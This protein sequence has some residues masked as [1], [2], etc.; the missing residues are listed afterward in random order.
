MYRHYPFYYGGLQMQI[1][2]I[3]VRR[4]GEQPVTGEAILGQR[5]QPGPTGVEMQPAND[6]DGATVDR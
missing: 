6:S 1:N 4:C 2:G 3:I 5:R